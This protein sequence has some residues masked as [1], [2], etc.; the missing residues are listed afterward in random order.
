MT[1][2]DRRA[3]RRGHGD[4][5][6]STAPSR[7]RTTKHEELRHALTRLLDSGMQAH[8]PLPSEREL[9]DRFEVSRVTVRHALAD[10]VQRGRVYRVHGAGTFVAEPVVRKEMT[11]SSFS[12]DM[13]ARGLVASSRILAVGREVAGAAVGQQLQLS[14]AEEVVHL[15]RL[16]LAN[17]EPMCLE[18][19]HLPVEIAGDVVTKLHEKS[20][21]Y[22]LLHTHAGVRVVRAE[23]QLRPTVL[24]RE[25]AAL[26]DVPPLSPALLTTRVTFD[27]RG[28]RVEY[29]KSLYRGDRYSIEVNLWRI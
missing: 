2:G 11:L 10:L 25:E 1:A 27:E 18:D 3:R 22:E 20:S 23:Q 4:L 8:E 28:R 14:P 16:R 9:M 15:T 26:L 24:S 17:S 21:L 6:P 12:E 5:G 7:H 19:T 13:A 29:A